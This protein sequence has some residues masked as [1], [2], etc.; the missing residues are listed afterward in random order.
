[1]GFL[2]E[3]IIR[4][5]PLPEEES[6]HALFFPHFEAGVA[7]VRQIVQERV[8]ASMLRLSTAVETATN[9]ALAGHEQLIGLMQ[10]G[11]GLLGQGDEKCMLM[12]GI[13]GSEQ[14]AR[15]ARRMA[16]HIAHGHGG[17]H[18]GRYMGHQWHKTRFT[19]PYLRNTMWELGYAV[20]T[21][22]TAAPWGQL[23]A[24]INNLD[25]ALRVAMEGANERVHVFTHVSHVYPDGASIYTTYVFRVQPDPGQTLEFWCKLKTAASEAIVAGGGTISHQHGVGLDHRSY[26]QTEKGAL[27]MAAL[28]TACRTFDPGGIMNPGKLIGRSA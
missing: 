26:L 1:M 28:T 15:S 13:S 10:R 3:A 22:E 6:F 20:D 5:T 4:V 23:P 24:L 14:L 12:L 16:L 21:V 9:L 8:P 2:V 27:G 17:F 25:A 19:T 18:V 11:L 7:A